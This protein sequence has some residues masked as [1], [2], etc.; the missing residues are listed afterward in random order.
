MQ[1]WSWTRRRI[2][3]VLHV[4]HVLHE[5]A[6][7][8]I[9]REGVLEVSVC[10]PSSSLLIVCGDSSWSCSIVHVSQSDPSLGQCLRV[11]ILQCTLRRTSV[12]RCTSSLQFTQIEPKKNKLLNSADL[13]L[14]TAASWSNHELDSPMMYILGGKN[15]GSLVDPSTISATTFG[16]WR[17]RLQ[18]YRDLGKSCSSNLMLERGTWMVENLMVHNARVKCSGNISQRTMHKTEKKIQIEL[19]FYHLRDS[20]H[21]LLASHSGT[22]TVRC[23]IHITSFIL[24]HSLHAC[25]PCT[26]NIYA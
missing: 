5:N 20:A 25:T 22:H 18:N 19:C 8:Q 17:E 15:V 23:S 1:R 12:L 2:L 21:C 7:I 24:M 6:C 13:Q 11:C 3:H 16:A 26:F 14:H 4:L 10:G 9:R